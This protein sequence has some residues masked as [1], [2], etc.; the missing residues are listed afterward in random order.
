MPRRE[1]LGF[2]G[3]LVFILFLLHLVFS[4]PI[5]K[6]GLYSV[7]SALMHANGVSIKTDFE[8]EHRKMMNKCQFQG[9]NE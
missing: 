2:P 1:G 6:I 9:T 7:C 8:T 3:H 4:L 5:V